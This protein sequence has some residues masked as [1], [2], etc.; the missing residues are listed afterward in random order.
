MFSKVENWE[1][2]FRFFSFWGFKKK[3]CY[4]MAIWVI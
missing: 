1:C 3:G 4:F 2:I